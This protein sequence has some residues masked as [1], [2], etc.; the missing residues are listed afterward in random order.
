MTTSSIPSWLDTQAYPFD[1]HYMPFGS[2]R[3]HFVDVGEGPVILFVHGTP[4]WSFDFRMQIKALS[5]DFRCIAID[6][7]GFGLSDKDSD[8]DYSTQAHAQRLLEFIER[9]DL[10]NIHLVLHDFGGPIGVQTFYQAT[11]RF[12]SITLINTWL[13]SSE[14]DPDYQKMKKILK[15]PLLPFLYKYLN[16]SARFILPAA[17][18]DKKLSKPLKRQY[19][20]PF[21]QPSQRYG[22]IA[23]AKSLLHDQPWFESLWERRKLLESLPLHLIWGMKDPVIGQQHLEKWQQAFPKANTL[24]LDTAGHFPQEEEAEAMTSFLKTALVKIS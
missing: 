1:H 23:F 5:R 16:F 12:A 10:K 2:H 4:S 19:T 8:A 7:L 24:K 3:M 6:H 14:G 17:F 15:S 13:W 20:A 22:T 18:G 9:L 21:A 11:E